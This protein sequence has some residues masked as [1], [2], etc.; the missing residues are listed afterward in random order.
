MSISATHK[1]AW[2]DF[3]TYVHYIKINSFKDILKK[4]LL[5]PFMQLLMFVPTH[6]NMHIDFAN[7]LFCFLKGIRAGPHSSV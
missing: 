7:F 5:G 6:K 2:A 3:F 4:I 1:K